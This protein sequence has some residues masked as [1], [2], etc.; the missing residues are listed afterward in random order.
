MT[1]MAQPDH[2]VIGQSL[3]EKLDKKQ[4]EA[5]KQ[6]PT[7]KDIWKYINESTGQNY[8]IYQNTK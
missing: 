4:K 7:E 2:M 5:F 1:S 8:L 6:Q 3:Y